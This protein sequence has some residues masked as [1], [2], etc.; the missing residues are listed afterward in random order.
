MPPLPPPRTVSEVNRALLECMREMD[1]EATPVEGDYPTGLW[2]YVG[3]LDRAG[4][5]RR[6]N[7]SEVAWTCRLGSM[8]R[9]RGWDAACEQRYPGPTRDRCDTV[10]AWHNGPPWWIEVKGAW[11]EVFDPGRPNAAFQKHLHATAHDVQKLMSLGVAHASGVSLVLVGFDRNEF[12]ISE[13]DL[14]IV[15]SGMDQ[16]W[17]EAYTEWEVRGRVAF[18]TRVW[19]WSRSFLL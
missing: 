11:R 14:A 9:E 18:R 7:N 10:V 2:W 1:S 6:Q 15:R 3:H 4:T 12:P 16:E 13:G 5:A 17:V 8:F 19:S